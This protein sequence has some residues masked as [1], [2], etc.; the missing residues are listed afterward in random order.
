MLPQRCHVMILLKTLYFLNDIHFSFGKE[1]D[2]KPNSHYIL[3]CEWVE[4]SFWFYFGHFS[5]AMHCGADNSL[6]WSNQFSDVVDSSLSESDSSLSEFESESS[7]SQSSPW[8]PMVIRLNRVPF[9]PHWYM[10][11]SFS[12]LNLVNKWVVIFFSIAYF[13]KKNISQ[14]LANTIFD[15]R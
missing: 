7:L 5:S 10:N 6:L 1:T 11:Y 4:R 9:S 3:L 13:E 14:M 8:V 15:R 12:N 2:I